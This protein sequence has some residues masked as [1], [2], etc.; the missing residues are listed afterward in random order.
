MKY[1]PLPQAIK[2]LFPGPY[3]YDSKHPMTAAEF[4]LN[5]RRRPQIMIK[6]TQNVRP[7]EQFQSPPVGR[8][9]RP[10]TQQR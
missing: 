4:D 10:N 8:R 1:L 2:I 3:D 9:E 7:V 6:P 5:E